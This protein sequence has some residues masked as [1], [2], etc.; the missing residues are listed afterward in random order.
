MASKA[1]GLNIGFVKIGPGSP[2]WLAGQPKQREGSMEKLKD[3]RQLYVNWL[4][5][6]NWRTGERWTIA[7]G[8]VDVSDYELRP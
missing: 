7:D 2:F 6:G 3:G 8:L 5:A 1:S 4:Y